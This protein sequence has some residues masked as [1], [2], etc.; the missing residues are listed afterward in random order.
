MQLITLR[1]LQRTV[2]AIYIYGSFKSVLDAKPSPAAVPTEPAAQAVGQSAAKT[3]TDKILD[4]ML[5]NME[6]AG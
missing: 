2:E 4:P 1:D 3:P 5:V 6:A